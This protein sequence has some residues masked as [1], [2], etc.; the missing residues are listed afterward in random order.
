MLDEIETEIGIS[1]NACEVCTAFNTHHLHTI[2]KI[3]Q[4]TAEKMSC[5]INHCTTLPLHHCTCTP[6]P[7]LLIATFIQQSRH[8]IT[9]RTPLIC[10]D[11]TILI[12]IR[13]IQVF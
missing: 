7:L 3:S 11:M 9:H 8:I 6:F 5:T 13:A 4:T 12:H 2:S 10:T 1:F